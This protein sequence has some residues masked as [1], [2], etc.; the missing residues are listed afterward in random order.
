MPE[1]IKLYTDEH[2]SKAVVRGLKERGVDTLA[3]SEAGMLCASD[4]EHLPFARQERSV[5]CTEDE[6]FFRL[7]AS[8]IE[9]SRIVYAR[10]QTIV[11]EMIY[12]R[13]GSISRLPEKGVLRSQVA[14]LANSQ[15]FAHRATS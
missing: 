15:R 11:G 5:L 7:R 4:E 2:V 8:G 12:G 3:V 9:T 10:Q 1:R 13:K 6:D 14:A